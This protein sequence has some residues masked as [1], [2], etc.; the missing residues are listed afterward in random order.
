MIEEKIKEQYGEQ[1]RL[2]RIEEEKNNVF[3]QKL[4][5]EI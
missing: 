1:V 5:R 2:K 3:H 4:M